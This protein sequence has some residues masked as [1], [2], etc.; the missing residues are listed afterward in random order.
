MIL[1]M[2][3]FKDFGGNMLDLCS[4]GKTP[5]E[6][7]SGDIFFM[8]VNRKLCSL[9]S[10]GKRLLKFDISP[11]SLKDTSFLVNL[12]SNNSRV[13][14]CVN[15]KHTVWCHKGVLGADDDKADE[16]GAGEEEEDEIL[17]ELKK[18]QAELRAL[19]HQNAM[20][21]RFLQKQAKEELQNQELRK[22]MAAADAEVLLWCSKIL[23]GSLWF[24][25]Y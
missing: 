17:A 6:Y 4:F 2:F 5:W 25:D 9:F 12:P 13:I 20:M 8:L 23:V 24:L 11:T 14:W 16:S 22:K 10:F 15:C 1:I 18:K 21:L 19:S 3:L 7:N